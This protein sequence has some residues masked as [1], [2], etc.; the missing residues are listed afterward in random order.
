MLQMKKYLNI[1]LH[2][3]NSKDYNWKRNVLGWSWLL[4]QKFK[5]VVFWVSWSWNNLQNLFNLEYFIQIAEFKAKATLSGLDD[6][7]FM[8]YNDGG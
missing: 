6:K 3:Y 5:N 4:M 1:A 8:F 2:P 7:S